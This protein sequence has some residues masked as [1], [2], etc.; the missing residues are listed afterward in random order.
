[1]ES[2]LKPT[3]VLMMGRALAFGGTFMIPLVLA[4][5]FDQA[6][7]GTYKQLLLVFSTLYVVAPLGMSESLYYFLPREPRRAGA[8]VANTMLFLLAA[9]L[10][11]L[12]LLVAGGERLATGL[13][14]ADAAPYLARVGAFAGLMLVTAP[15]ETIMIARRRYTGA[16]WTYAVSDLGRAALLAIPAA[17]TG[18]LL[19]LFDG[20]LLFA[21]LRLAFTLAYLRRELGRDLRP[22]LGALRAQLAYALPFGAAAL[23]LI[24]QD[25][26]HQYAVSSHFG[27]AAFAIYSVGCLQVPLVDFIAGP[28]GNVVMV[29]MSELRQDQDGVLRLWHET[30]RQLALVFV[31][32]V[33]LLEVVARDA[34]VSLYTPLYVES[35]PIFRL[36]CL[37]I[38]FSALQT[39]AV[40]RVHAR[41]RFILVLNLVRLAVIVAT[42]GWALRAFGILGA[43]LA[44]VAALALAK[45]LALVQVGLLTGSGLRRLLPWGSLAAITAVS[46]A[47]AAPALLVASALEA[48]P[49]ARL[50]SATAAYLLTYLVLGIPLLLS[51]PERR[52]LFTWAA[53]PWRRVAPEGAVFGG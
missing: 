53:A 21:A 2:I 5:V 37:T 27:V 38:L 40:L 14:N 28:A 46:A 36:W 10:G 1:M 41:T 8:Y 9:G 22:D 48:P 4:R 25:T 35:V 3:L 20:A 26:Y 7:F 50:A 24:A 42:I 51:G 39:D 18:S 19:W 43:A 45:G 31:P 33:A 30:T 34:I 17:L 52:A 29:G 11:C 16:A 13:A 32:L 44:A 15:L 49:F 12:A 47:A 6:Q 23:V